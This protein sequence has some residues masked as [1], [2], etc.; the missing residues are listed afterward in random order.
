MPGISQ[1]FSE[2]LAFGGLLEGEHQRLD[3]VT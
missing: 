1:E 2:E 3:G